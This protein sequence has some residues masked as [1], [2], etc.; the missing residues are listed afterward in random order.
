MQ[1]LNSQLKAM[2]EDA[3]KEVYKTIFSRIRNEFVKGITIIDNPHV[4][5]DILNSILSMSD[6]LR[7]L[8]LN[9]R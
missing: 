3:F 6:E 2:D 8:F 4:Y 1:E 9:Y 7:D 5:V